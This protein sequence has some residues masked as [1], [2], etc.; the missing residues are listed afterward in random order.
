[1]NLNEIINADCLEVMRT[2]EAS[3]VDLLVTDPP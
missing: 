1:M 2:F 3:S